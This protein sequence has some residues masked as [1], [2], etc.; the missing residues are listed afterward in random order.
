MKKIFLVI[1]TIAASLNFINAQQT[2]KIPVGILPT[3]Y[4]DGNSYK[5]TVMV[6]EE[7]AN[8]FLKTNRF[9]IVDRSKI[10]ALRRER[11]LQKTEDFM[12]G[13][14]IEQSKG[15]GAKYLVS[16]VISDY[17]N[18]GDSCRFLL[19]LKVIDVETGEIV[20]SDKLVPK[21]GGFGKALLS[22]TVNVLLETQG[23]LTTKEKAFKNALDK[24]LPQIEEFVNKNFPIEFFIVE[25]QEKGKL[26]ISGGSSSGVKKGTILKVYEESMINV[27]GKELKRKKDIAEL[28]V[29]K[30]EDENF[31]TCTIKSG[32]KDLR[33]KINTNANIK[34]TFK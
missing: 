15:I 29:E 2:E 14:V 16:S 18:D 31:S 10:E 5:E 22:G 27:N 17:T 9:N 24:M 23:S 4:A 7:L 6:S 21:S 13:S 19:S 1:I 26:L 30:V 11:E 12:D 28:K 32:E 25:Q 34:I 3:S 33:E 8:A 20:A